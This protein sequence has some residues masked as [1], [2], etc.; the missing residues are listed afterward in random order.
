M[1]NPSD[2]KRKNHGHQPATISLSQEFFLGYTPMA[3]Y[4]RIKSPRNPS[5]G[6]YTVPSLRRRASAS[7]RQKP[8]LY[9]GVNLEQLQ[10]L[11]YWVP[12]AFY[13]IF[14]MYSAHYSKWAIDMGLV[15]SNVAHLAMA[16]HKEK[17]RTIKLHIRR[18]SLGPIDRRVVTISLSY[19]GIS[20]LLLQLGLRM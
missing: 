12:Y 1:E 17:E 13:I 14:S 16:T 8:G 3:A 11:V 2:V 9:P 20:T 18:S 10:H 7:L 15:V 5:K 19:E 6:V 4:K